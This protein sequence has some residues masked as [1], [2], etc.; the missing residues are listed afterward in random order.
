VDTAGLRPT[1]D[2]VERLGLEVSARYLR[3]AVI[4]LACVDTPEAMESVGSLR[5]G[6]SGS[7]IVV[8]TKADLVSESFK[9]SADVAVSAHTGE[10]LALL[11]EKIEE[12]LAGVRGAPMPDAPVLTRARHSLAVQQAKRQLTEFVVTW[13]DDLLPAS[14]AATHVRAAG[15][16]L[17]ELIGIVGVDDVLDVVFRSF[18]VG[19]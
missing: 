7:I 15:D 5:A 8:A 14:V 16:A 6:T 12:R 13:R 18:C 1:E 19:K 2:A 10:G 3:K 17:S 11:L 4:V 9:T